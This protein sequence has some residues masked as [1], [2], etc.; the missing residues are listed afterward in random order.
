M[1]DIFDYN[2]N[3]HFSLLKDIIKKVKNKSCIMR[4]YFIDTGINKYLALEYMKTCY[5]SVSKI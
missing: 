2:K 1:T 5:K 4:R 3:K